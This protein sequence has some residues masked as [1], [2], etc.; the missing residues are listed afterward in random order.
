[1]AIEQASAQQ[2]DSPSESSIETTQL[3]RLFRLLIIVTTFSYLLFYFEPF[4]FGYMVSDVEAELLDW[5]GYDA[6]LEI[7]PSFNNLLFLLWIAA[8]IGLYNFSAAARALYAILLGFGIVSL[9][10]TGLQAS[11]AFPSF[12]I[13]ICSTCD[14]AILALAYFSP[15]RARFR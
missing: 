15:L 14:G 13:S 7:P 2:N 4:L 6:L 12:L 10:V 11:T 1:M 8:A 3:E 9:L 5:V